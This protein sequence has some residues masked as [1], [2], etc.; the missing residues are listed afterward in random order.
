MYCYSY[1]SVDVT[2]FFHN[3]CLYSSNLLVDQMVRKGVA[4]FQRFSMYYDSSYLPSVCLYINI[5]Y[6]LFIII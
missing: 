6:I 5:N 2:S 3:A 1:C 4:H